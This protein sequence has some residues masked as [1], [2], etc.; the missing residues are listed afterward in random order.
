ML[1]SLGGCRDP[2]PCSDCDVG[3]EQPIADFPSSDLPCG[4]ADLLTDDLNCG[5]CDV[6]CLVV[7]PETDYEAGHCSERQCGPLWYE[8]LYPAVPPNPPA[9]TCDQLC[10]QRSATCVEQGCSGKTAFSCGLVF[11][12]GC[13]LTSPG[14]L[15]WTG[16]CSEEVPWFSFDPG[17]QPKLGCCCR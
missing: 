6:E 10:A 8:E 15:D 2:L 5:S 7:Y 3:D 13:D 11:G 17:V 9:V 16:P 14:A 1:V 12:S 4:G